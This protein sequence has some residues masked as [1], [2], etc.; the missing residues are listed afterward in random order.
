MLTF[1]VV[2]LVFSFI[3]FFIGLLLSS[4]DFPFHAVILA[5]ELPAPILL[6]L[7]VLVAISNSKSSNNFYKKFASFTLN[8]GGC[9]FIHTAEGTGIAV[10]TEQRL[11][12][13][14]AGCTM[15]KYTFEQVRDWEKR[16]IT[17]GAVFGT[18]MAVVAAN[19]ACATD[20]KNATG[21]FLSVKDIDFPVWQIRFPS[22]QAIDRW[23]EI[24][25]QCINE[26]Q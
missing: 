12:F 14:V 2:L 25:Q 21:I 6:V 24:L 1:L 16:V 7:I 20:A 4:A 13:L 19:V 22:K 5:C 15:K 11:L 10:N 26:S 23:F 3:P 9:N 8:N 18:G 17:P